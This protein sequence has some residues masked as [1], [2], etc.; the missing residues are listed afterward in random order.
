MAG[1]AFDR[2]RAIVRRRLAV[3][4]RNP[5]RRPR[6]PVLGAVALLAGLLPAA[7]AGPVAAVS[8]N[9]VIGQVYGGG[10]NAG[11]TYTNDFVEL[12]NRGTLPV[13]LAGWSVQ[14]ASATGTGNFGGNPVT[15]VNGTL[16]P[17]QYYLVQMAAGAG[18]TTALPTPDAIGSVNMSGTA[19][20][21]IVSNQST[22][23]ACNGGSAPCNEN[24][25][26]LEQK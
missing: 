19:G 21:V 12:F 4:H 7:I 9:I 23:L 8:P 14:Y 2:S 15:I 5:S 13:N 26:K 11:A 20:K 18:G 17:G 1:H 6:L 16:N 25:M 10:G 24:N 22:G 3:F